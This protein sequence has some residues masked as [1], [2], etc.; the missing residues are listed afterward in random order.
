[1]HGELQPVDQY[2]S[3]G[4]AWRNKFDYPLNTDLYMQNYDHPKQTIHQQTF[5]LHLQWITYMSNEGSGPL[6]KSLFGPLGLVL[7]LDVYTWAAGTPREAAT[8][9]AGDAEARLKQMDN[10]KT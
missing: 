4:L 10:T 7:L 2:I 5:N 8:V 3:M 6:A 9:R 1:M